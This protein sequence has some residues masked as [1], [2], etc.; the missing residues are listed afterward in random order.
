LFNVGHS[1]ALDV[2]FYIK[3]LSYFGGE[4]PVAKQSEFIARIKNGPKVPANY[5]I[6]LFPNC[7]AR[8]E[9]YGLRITSD[10]VESAQRN[11]VF[12]PI[13]LG[14][15]QY[16]FAFPSKIEIH[17]TRFMYEMART[18]RGD[19]T[20]PAVRYDIPK[21]NLAFFISPYGGHE[22]T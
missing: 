7:D 8:L 13:V 17:E 11:G 5:G 22:A 6:V 21:Q 12:H 4:D 18:S 10:E 3:M 16:K 1:V 9:D 2:R 14:F 19:R 15:V 20:T